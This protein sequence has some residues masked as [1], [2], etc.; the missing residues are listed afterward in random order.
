[1]PEH[2][3]KQTVHKFRTYTGF[4]LSLPIL[5]STTNRKAHHRLKT[6]TWV[7]LYNRKLWI[8]SKNL[9]Q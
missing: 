1:M 9:L 5:Y 4:L 6:Q 3:S 7:F 8:H 2:V